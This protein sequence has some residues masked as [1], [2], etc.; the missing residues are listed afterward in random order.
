MGNAGGRAQKFASER[1]GLSKFFR[2][3]I[4][5]TEKFFGEFCDEIITVSE[6]ISNEYRR[7]HKITEGII[8]FEIE[9]SCHQDIF[10]NDFFTLC[11]IG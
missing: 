7:I 10:L 1:N 8:I 6:S 9:I 11:F 3:I 2:Q 4:R 5:S